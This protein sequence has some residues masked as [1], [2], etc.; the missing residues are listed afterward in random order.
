MQNDRLSHYIPRRLDDPPKFLFWD[1]DIA[2]IALFA[3][4][5]G[6]WSG[7]IWAGLALGIGSAIGYGKL[8]AGKHPGMAVHFAYWLFGF[9]TLKTIP[10]GHV[11]EFIG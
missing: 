6:V 2:M 10:G 8:R 1:W 4:L 7:M 5:I 11:R 9:P 3:F